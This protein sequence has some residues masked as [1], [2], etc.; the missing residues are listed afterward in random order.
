MYLCTL[1]LGI[2]IQYRN[3]QLLISWKRW[4]MTHKFN[5]TNC[6]LWHLISNDIIRNILNVCFVHLKVFNIFVQSVPEY[7]HLFYV[8]CVFKSILQTQLI[9][10]WKRKTLTSRMI[11][12]CFLLSMVDKKIIIW[13]SSNSYSLV[14]WITCSTVAAYAR[15]AVHSW[16]TIHQ[17]LSSDAP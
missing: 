7:P 6:K 15:V 3:F 2:S 11:W 9:Y 5:F 10:H 12:N 16:C 8:C 4:K 17:L 14:L 1:D 13:N